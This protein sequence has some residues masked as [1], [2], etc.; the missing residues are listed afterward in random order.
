MSI[1]LAHLIF[2]DL[3]ALCQFFLQKSSD[4]ELELI[5]EHLQQKNE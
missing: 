5:E 4:E 1:K 3:D 2:K